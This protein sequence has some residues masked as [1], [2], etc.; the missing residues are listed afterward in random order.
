VLDE[1]RR[2][3]VVTGLLLIAPGIL[4]WRPNPALFTVGLSSL[5]VGFGLL[6]ACTLSS[7]RAQRLAALPVL[8]GLAYLGRYSYSVYLWHM[9]V[10]E[11]APHT[12]LWLVLA[13]DIVFAFVVGIVT[14]ELIEIPMLG[15]RE[16]LFP[17]PLARPAMSTTDAVDGFGAR[18]A[19]IATRP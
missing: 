11:I 9:A 4:F 14:A 1:H 3:L 15:I 8:A 19:A 6:L 16:R 10:Q 13:F 18:V 17:S 2:G 7:Q 5:A 12:N